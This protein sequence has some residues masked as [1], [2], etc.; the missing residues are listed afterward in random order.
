L[1]ALNTNISYMKMSK[2]VE[3]GYLFLNIHVNA[4]SF[5]SYNLMYVSRLI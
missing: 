2:D 4:V 1:D 3:K 5:H